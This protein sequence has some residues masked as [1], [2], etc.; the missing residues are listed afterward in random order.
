[1]DDYQTLMAAY[2][3]LKDGNTLQF[4]NKTYTFSHTP[5]LHKSIN[6][7][8]PATITR[9]N[10][11]TYSLKIGADE[12]SNFLILN[13]TDGIIANDRIIACLNQQNT[14]ATQLRF[15]LKVSGDTL[16]LDSP[17]KKT[18]GNESSY[19]AGTKIFKNINFFYLIST[20]NF[21]GTGS[22]FTNLTFDG[23]RDNNN[24]SF[25][26]NLNTGILSQNPGYTVYRNCTFI[27][28]PNETIVGHNARIEN[29][30]F[31]NLNGSGFH[32]S[33]DRLIVTE[34][35]IHSYILNS[36]FEN[37][38]QINTRITGHSEGA[39]THSNSGGY[40][41]ATGDAFINVGEN[42]LGI[43]YPSVSVN[44][45]GTSNIEFTGNAIN[46][47]SSKIVFGISSLPGTIHDVRIERNIIISMKVT[48][49]DAQ[50]AQ[51]PDIVIK[52]EN[53]E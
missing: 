18:F 39:I 17:L 37:T 33:I 36:T 25:T 13:S 8:G 51:R 47:D 15:V 45:W 28:S 49:L 43:L 16:F 29:C 32:T 24:G 3:S 5:L 6:F 46:S 10:Q 42:V 35:Q 19:P 4:E 9:E 22:T 40:Y 44:D 11:I 53:G 21:P 27:N 14:G 26:W 20:V 31:K 34:Q 23:N 30:I 7:V 48:N 50:L 2:D 12:N 1:M 41:T 38:N 52:Q